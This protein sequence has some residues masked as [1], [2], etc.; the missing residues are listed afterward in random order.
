MTSEYSDFLGLCRG[1]VSTSERVC[2][3]CMQSCSGYSVE[4]H[5]FELAF[6]SLGG[7]LL[8]ILNY[9]ASSAKNSAIEFVS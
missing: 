6:Q 5:M 9:L 8:V 4:I 3:W 2:C 1:L 7:L